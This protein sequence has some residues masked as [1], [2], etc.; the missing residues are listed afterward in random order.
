MSDPTPKTHDDI[1]FTERRGDDSRPAGADGAI[2]RSQSDAVFSSSP[3][4]DTSQVNNAPRT[5]H[6]SIKE[7]E[8]VQPGNL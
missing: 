3:S 7:L 4:S 2:P 5:H 1:G 8:R 6:Y